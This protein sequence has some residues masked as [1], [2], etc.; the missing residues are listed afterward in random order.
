MMIKLNDLKDSRTLID[1]GRGKY[2]DE[3]GRSTLYWASITICQGTDGVAQREA[4]GIYDTKSKYRGRFLYRE[5]GRYMTSPRIISAVRA[6]VDQEIANSS[7]GFVS[8]EELFHCKNM[9][10]TCDEFDAKL[11]EIKERS[12]TN[13]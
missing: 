8:E 13:D 5:T 1:V 2:T 12:Q 11:A 4:C 3:S 7:I 9:A 6:F 10:R